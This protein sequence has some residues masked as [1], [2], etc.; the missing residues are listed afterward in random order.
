MQPAM[1]GGAYLASFYRKEQRYTNEFAAID[2][3]CTEA[4][5]AP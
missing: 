4:K 3:F 2:D 1:S 5:R